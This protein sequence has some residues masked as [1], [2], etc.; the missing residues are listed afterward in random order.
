MTK[1]TGHLTLRSDVYSFGVVLLELL[2]GRRVVEDDRQVYTE[3]TLVDWAM[4]FLIDSRRILRIMDTKLGGQ[5]SKKGAQAAAALVLKCLNT[6][7]KHRPTMVNVLSALEALH[8]SNSFPR[9]P[10]SGTDNNNNSVPRTPK[11]GTDNH[12]ATK[13]SSHHHSHKSITNNTRKH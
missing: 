2:T 12:H 7:P 3:E 1:Q 13:H 11:S 4:P 6:D 5:Y 9:K 10:K 8:S